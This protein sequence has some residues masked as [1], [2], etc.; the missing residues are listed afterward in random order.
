MKRFGQ[1]A[2]VRDGA[3]RPSRDRGETAGKLRG[4]REV[5]WGSHP[6]GCGLRDGWDPSEGLPVLGTAMRSV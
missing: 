3:E 6:S 1:L 2:G 4:G 5:W